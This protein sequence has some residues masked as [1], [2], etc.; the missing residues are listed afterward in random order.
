MESLREEGNDYEILEYLRVYARR[1]IGLQD[2]A[3]TLS[4]LKKDVDERKR[5]MAEAHI[6]YLEHL[7]DEDRGEE[8][9]GPEDNTDVAD[10]P[11]KMDTFLNY[12]NDMYFEGQLDLEDKAM[13][14]QGDGDR[15]VQ[16]AFEQKRQIFNSED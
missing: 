4:A 16:G 8:G 10:L 15:R 5:K 14:R 11:E 6:E 13:L 2:L 1:W 12:V 9:T 7:D 3:P